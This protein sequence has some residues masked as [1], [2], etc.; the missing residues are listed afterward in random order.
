M[1]QRHGLKEFRHARQR[2]R[3]HHQTDDHLLDAEHSIGCGPAHVDGAQRVEREPE[4]D[5]V[6][7]CYH[8]PGNARRCA[9]GV[10]EVAE[11]R[12]REERATGWARVLRE[13]VK[14]CTVS[15]GLVWF[16]GKGTEESFRGQ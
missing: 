4:R 11:M 9:N 5:A 15:Q 12:M 3:I 1:Q 7:G 16:V 14:V 2:T 13:R 6:H 8:Q 10:S